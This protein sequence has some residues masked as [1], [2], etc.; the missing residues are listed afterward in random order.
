MD[1]DNGKFSVFVATLP[2]ISDKIDQRFLSYNE[3]CYNISCQN[4]IVCVVC[5]NEKNHNLSTKLPGISTSH[6]SS[7]A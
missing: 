7:T 4:D 5:N 2:D 3:K 6:N 1:E